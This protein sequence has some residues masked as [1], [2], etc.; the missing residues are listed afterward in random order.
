MLC[1]LTSV[2]IE[3][4]GAQDGDRISDH[5]SIEEA[6]EPPPESLQPLVMLTHL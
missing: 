2:P 1:D 4:H 6:V 3:H 5:C